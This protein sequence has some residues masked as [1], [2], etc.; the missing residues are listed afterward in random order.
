M[1]TA[2]VT[3][4]SARFASGAIGSFTSTC[5]LEWPH[6]VGLHL[7][8]EG[9]AVELS[10]KEVRIDLG[11]GP[12][13]SVASGDPFEREDRAFIEAVQGRPDR[14]RTTYA[15]ALRTHRVTT[16]VLRSAAEGRPLPVPRTT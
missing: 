13:V 8:G 11:H 7:F 14:T 4:A 1:D 2:E 9:V 16:T 10:E 6:R 15:G 12:T 3:A 5:L